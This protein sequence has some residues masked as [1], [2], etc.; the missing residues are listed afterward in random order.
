MKSLQPVIWS[1]GTVLNPQHLQTQDR[2]IESAFQFRLGAL[3]FCPW[4]FERLT[5][6]Q[7]ELGAGNFAVSAASGLF[8]DGLPFDIPDCD[9]GPP[10]KPL[11]PYFESKPESVDVYLA[12][13]HYR[14]RGLN[15]SLAQQT[16]DTRYVAEV[17]MATDENSGTS[18]RPVRVARK[19]FRLLVEGESRHGMSAI[20]AARVR[21]NAT[22]TFELDPAFVPPLLDI[23]ASDHVMSILRRLVGILSAKSGTLAGMRRQKN[24]SLADFSSADIANFW[25]LYTVNTYFPLLNHLFATRRG[26]PEA[27]YALL[28]SLAGALT[29][30]SQKVQPHDLPAYDHEDLTTCLSLIDERVRELLETVV[31]SHCVSLPLK[32]VRPSIYATAIENDSYLTHTKMYLAIGSE[33]KAAELIKR[34]PQLIKVCSATYIDELV[35]RA[36]A[37]VRLTHT[38]SPPSAIPVK[39]NYEYFSLNQ[40]GAAWEAVTRARNLA[41]YVPSDIPAPQ[42]ELIVLLPQAQ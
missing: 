31:P 41:A 30:F 36:V 2:F 9:P 4:G 8:G 38:P 15:I 29:T 33:L 26:H 23:S 19:N 11:A 39:L 17:I 7:A 42:L 6:N 13:P 34:A 24:Q 12:V 3:N 35:K 21:R 25:L 40:S 27:L 5:V 14:E 37:G 18:E 28:T 10:P 20:R 1:K 16:A 22:G 32:L